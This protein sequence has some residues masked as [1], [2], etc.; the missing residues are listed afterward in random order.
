MRE[1]IDDDHGYGVWLKD[2][3]RGFVLN[4][5]RNPGPNYAVL[6]RAECQTIATSRD[7]GA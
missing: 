4:V 6:H 5:R 3:P 7:D 2:Y 1:F